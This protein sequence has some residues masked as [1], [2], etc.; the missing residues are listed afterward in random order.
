MHLDRS[1]DNLKPT[2]KLQNMRKE[3]DFYL[4]R[5]NMLISNQLNDRLNHYHLLN[6][7]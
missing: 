5:L 1:L 3:L 2:A 6:E 7:N 4:K